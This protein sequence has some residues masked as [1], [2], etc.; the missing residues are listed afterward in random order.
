MTATGEHERASAT[1]RR[2]A[3]WMLWILLPLVVV[4][5][6]GGETVLM[7]FGPAFRQG[8]LWLGIV[9]IACATNA[10]IGL[11]E[12][13]I[14]VQRPGLN[15]LHSSITCVIGLAAN[16]LLIPRFGVTGAAFGILIPYLV[17]G[18][19]RGNALRRV[20]HW[21]NPWRAV[22]PPILAAIAAFI[23][24]LVCRTLLEGI[25]AQITAVMLFLVTYGL[26]WTYYRLRFKSGLDE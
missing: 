20:F 9:A 15:L 25:A 2:L 8:S 5:L 22:T 4:M 12:T 23:P 26:G 18:I 17:Q 1:Y 16:L 19:L 10:F 3:Q 6:L 24:A 13:A 14:M 21:P 7:I 11:A